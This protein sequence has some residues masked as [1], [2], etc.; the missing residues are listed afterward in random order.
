MNG[1][2]LLG[3]ASSLIILVTLFE[4]LRR[5]RLREKFALIWFLIAV[6]SVIVAL[7]P[8]V[9]TKATEVLGLNLP[10]NLLFFVASIVLLLLSLQ[11]SYELG[12]LEERTRTL[13]EE[14]A[15]LRL[16]LDRATTDPSPGAPDVR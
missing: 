11:H 16:E 9:L 7:V 14:V 15:L 4:M 5:H 2:E 12:R 3:L 13:A 6:G 10:S 1:A 8:A